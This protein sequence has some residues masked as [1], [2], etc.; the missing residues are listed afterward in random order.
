MGVIAKEK[1]AKRAK[2]KP[3]QEVPV[4]EPES[5]FSE[6][7][8][9]LRSTSMNIGNITTNAEDVLVM[10]K[11][12]AKQY[13]D[14]SKYEGDEKGAKDD[15]ALLRKQK[16]A[17]KA[18]IASI[19]EAWNEPM[20]P[21]LDVSKKIIKEF[22]YA[23]E[24]IDEWVKDGEA[25]VKEKKR[26]TIQAYFDGKDFDLVPMDKFFNDKWLNK[27]FEMRDIKKEV[28][29]AIAAIYSNIKILENIA[30]H[31]TTAKAFYLETLDMGAAMRQVETL[32]ANAEKL[33]REKIEREER[34]H[35]AQVARNAAD[36]RLEGWGAAKD[37]RAHSLA[38]E[39]L[40]FE[41][42]EIPE[43]PPVPK[44]IEF[45]LRFSGTEE[46]LRG[47]REYMTANNIAYVKIA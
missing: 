24:N 1:P 33:A 28:D 10:V 37:E 16:E 18:A 5:S 21:F 39:A 4:Q 3:E 41:E 30:E 13:L 14:T 15:R 36:E 45:T 8:I 42:P 26:E 31:G 34:E 47:L 35:R 9:I 6:K 2:A 38:A 23:I 19:Q 46:Q 32:K 7:A 44:I 12:K 11:E 27:T 40:D 29:E 17:A 43:G 20:V 25:K 22:D